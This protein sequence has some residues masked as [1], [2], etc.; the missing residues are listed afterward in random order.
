LEAIVAQ[1]GILT[2]A[3]GGLIDQMLLLDVAPLSLGIE[4]AGGRCRA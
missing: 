2:G 3:K 1:A 4:A